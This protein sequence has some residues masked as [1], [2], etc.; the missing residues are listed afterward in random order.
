[1][2]GNNHWH[3]TVGGSS[4]R[5]PPG[6]S[7]NAGVDEDRQ[8]I[9]HD[10]DQQSSADSPGKQAEEVGPK[11][12]AEPAVVLPPITTSREWRRGGS[13]SRWT[14]YGCALGVLALIALLVFGVALARRTAWLAID[15]MERRLMTAVERRNEPAERLRTSRNLERFR[16]QLRIAR[17]PY[18]QMGEF[19]KLVRSVLADGEMTAAEVDQVN[20]Y[21][22]SKLPTFGAVEVDR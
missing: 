13:L 5:E 10:T 22:E 16:V 4:Q 9:E 12:S 19:M 2:H 20:Q 6:V 3:R 18:P 21:L 15:G 1:V 14:T 17:D 8:P 7:Y 11:A